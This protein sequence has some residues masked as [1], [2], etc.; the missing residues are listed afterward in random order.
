[1]MNTKGYIF[2]FGGTLDTAGCLEAVP[3]FHSIRASGALDFPAP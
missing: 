3:R 1:M 2:D